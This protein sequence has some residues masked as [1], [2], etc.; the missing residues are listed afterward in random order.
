MPNQAPLS[1]ARVL[2]EELRENDYAESLDTWS[3]RHEADDPAEAAASHGGMDRIGIDRTG[4]PESIDPVHPVAINR[5]EKIHRVDGIADDASIQPRSAL[6]AIIRLQSTEIERLVLEND[7]LAV[8]LS[9]VHQF[10]QN[11]QNQRRNLE[12]QLREA[13]ARIEPPALAFDIEEIRS[14]ARD[15]MSAE[16]KS[17]LVAILDIGYSL[18]SPI[19]SRSVLKTNKKTPMYGLISTHSYRTGNKGKF[20]NHASE[21]DTLFLDLLESSLPRSAEAETPAA[22]AGEAPVSIPASLAAEVMND[23]HRLPAILTRPLEELMSGPGPAGSAPH[24]VA[25]P[26]APAPPEETCLGRPRPPRHEARPSVMP[27]AF[28]WTSLLS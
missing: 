27:S 18:R 28:A 23:F 20:H 2:Y 16:I 13:N 11:E 24:P 17:V 21:V 19:R 12:R 6:A 25:D 22:V 15:G 26:P 14:A 10:H 3:V 1:P 7:R 4:D 9:A 8:Q 5:V